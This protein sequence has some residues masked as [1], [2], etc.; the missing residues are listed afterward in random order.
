MA[1]DHHHQPI[2]LT[3]VSKA[4]IVGIA[5]NAVFVF[6][7]AGVGLHI[8]SLSLL[9]DAGHNFADVA[10]LILSLIAFKLH[11]VKSNKNYTYGYKKTSIIVAIIN[12]IVLLI[13]IA[14]IA[15]EAIIHIMHPVVLSGKT[16]AWVALAGVFVNGISAIFFLQDK[17]KDLN[18]KSAFMHLAADALISFGIVIG[19]IIIYFTHLYWIDAV[20]SL[21]IAIII[22]I[23]TWKL[24]RDSIKLSLDGVPENINIEKISD[25]ILKTDGIKSMH[26]LHIW[27]ISTTENAMTVH[28]VLDNNT[29]I[30]IEQK[31]KATLKHE[32]KHQ[33]IQH[34]TI[35]TEL[36]DYNC[37]NEDC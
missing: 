9:S 29:T 16:I 1:N 18:I 10:S 7:Q 25:T 3:N 35:E 30:E 22:L 23:T 11:K 31:I 12:A 6:V 36:E 37:N 5:L 27:A 33:N 19:G 21:I 13:S 14:I 15:Y 17:D 8:K 26:H 2:V 20:L 32:L 4:F 34:I 24:L 28:I